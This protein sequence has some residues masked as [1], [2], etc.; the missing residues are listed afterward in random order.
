VDVVA[1]VE[2]GTLR[3]RVEDPAGRPLAGRR[4]VLRAEGVDLGPA[5]PD[6]EGGRAAIR[7]GRG[8]V[9]VQDAESG[10]AAVVEV[11]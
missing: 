11:P 3:W 5:E 10:V 6:G 1:T 4:V 8:L 7:G 9:A 2:Q